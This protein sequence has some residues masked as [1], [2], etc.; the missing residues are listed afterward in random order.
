MKPVNKPHPLIHFS[1][2]KEIHFLLPSAC[3]QSE[4]EH[5]RQE[6]KSGSFALTGFYFKASLLDKRASFQSDLTTLTV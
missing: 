3:C 5:S 6:G 2:G 1:A 4:Q